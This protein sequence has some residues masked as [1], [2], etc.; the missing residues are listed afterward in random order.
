MRTGH[1]FNKNGKPASKK[2]KA[3]TE[4]AAKKQEK[5]KGKEKKEQ[6]AKN[7][8]GICKEASCRAKIIIKIEGL[9]NV[10]ELVLANNHALGQSRQLPC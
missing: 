10:S 1:V 7:R 9:C 5:E 6:A 4:T 3:K 8:K 2:C